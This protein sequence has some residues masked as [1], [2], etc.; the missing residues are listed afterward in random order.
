MKWPH[1]QTELR[2]HTQVLVYGGDDEPLIEQ[3]PPS[4]GA[5]CYEV[6]VDALRLLVAISQ[7]GA[8]RT[9]LLDRAVLPKLLELIERCRAAMCEEEGS[10]R[11]S[12]AS[13]YRSR[14][15]SQKNSPQASPEGRRGTSP[16]RYRRA[17]VPGAPQHFFF[18]D[19]LQAATQSL[20]NLSTG[21]N[22][23]PWALTT[24]L[25]ASLVGILADGRLPAALREDAAR[26]LKNM[27]LDDD[28]RLGM[29]DNGAIEA[30][31]EACLLSGHAAGPSLSHRGTGGT[32]VSRVQSWLGSMDAAGAAATHEPA[33]DEVAEL[34]PLALIADG[35]RREG[36]QLREQAARAIGNLAVCDLLEERIVDTCSVRAL[37]G[38]LGM[39]VAASDAQ[40][41][42][43]ALGSLANLVRKNM[44]NVDIDRCKH[45]ID[46]DIDR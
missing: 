26:S 44:L 8:L 43:A 14:S 35:L 30:L 29:A 31:A 41:A 23:A 28:I 42:D 20:S 18:V 1:C 3:G 12:P 46:I 27:A 15:V 6:A 17:P 24:G 22:F 38:L 19:A 21:E 4:A 37:V 9:Q 7:H 32:A 11:A 45:T 10:R 13:Y 2:A 25:S 33:S 16:R 39:A 36:M 34:M 5:C 40:A